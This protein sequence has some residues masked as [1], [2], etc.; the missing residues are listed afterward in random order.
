MKYVLSFGVS[1]V[2]LSGCASSPTK[3][4]TA[5]S[6]ASAPAATEA[7]ATPPEPEE[8]TPEAPQQ[9]AAEAWAERSSRAEAA[10]APARPSDGTAA[11]PLAIGDAMESA[12]TTKVELTPAR[13][14][15]TKT[16]RD[17]EDG[18]KLAE[19]APTFD[20][21]AQKLG[22]RLGKPTWVENGKKRVWV[23]RDNT[24]CYRLVL[25][26]DGSIETETV[27]LNETRM[28]SALSQQNA[29]TGVVTNG[30]PGM[31]H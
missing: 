2:L 4:S 15:R 23:V 26:V 29:C 6:P 5:S 12:T 28:L 19:A 27:P 21:A 25:D 17:L 31:K 30:V 1:V 9:T 8:A 16:V 10:A 20:E 3:A 14:L 22:V 18:R 7:S 24:Q 13:L 11:D